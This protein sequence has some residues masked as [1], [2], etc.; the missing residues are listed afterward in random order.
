V[1]TNK[2]QQKYSSQLQSRKY[3][4]LKS[5]QLVYHELG[6][7]L[8]SSILMDIFNHQNNDRNYSSL[9]LHQ[10]YPNHNK[11]WDSTRMCQSEQK[12]G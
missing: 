2:S 5:N 9:Y 4:V 10:F 11:W 6:F 3:V 8:M 12:T 1:V 7:K